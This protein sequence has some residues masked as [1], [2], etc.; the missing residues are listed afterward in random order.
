MSNAAVQPGARWQRWRMGE[1]AEP[2][3]PATDD[4]DTGQTE[5]EARLAD[6]QR[7][8]AK[9]QADLEALRVKGEQEGWVAGHMTGAQ[10]GYD[11]G[12]LRGLALGR[13]QAEAEMAAYAADTIAPLATL[14]TNFQTALNGLDEAISSDLVDLAMA[15]GRQLAGDALQDAPAQ[16]LEVIHSLLNTDPPLVGQPRLHLS[17]D[18]HSLVK[19]KIGGELEVA[20][21]TIQPDAQ[22][23]RGECRVT[24][25]NGELDATWSARWDAIQAQRRAR[26]PADS[27]A[28]GV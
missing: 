7:A 20:G 25:T 6:A 22:L 14:V 18:D 10:D 2:A 15:T 28:E 26:R 12:F 1:L 17:A 23:V 4:G 16:V 3:S 27:T 8:E 21:W 19:E 13:Q 9:R 11:E 24:S 5:A